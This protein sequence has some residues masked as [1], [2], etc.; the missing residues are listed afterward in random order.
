MGACLPPSAPGKTELKNSAWMPVDKQGNAPRVFGHT[1]KFWTSASLFILG[2]VYVTKK[3]PINCSVFGSEIDDEDPDEQEGR[4]VGNASSL[5]E[6][7]VLLQT[8]TGGSQHWSR[9]AVEAT[10]ET[11]C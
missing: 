11:S 6:Q 2:Y 5:R 10:S 4:H 3:T 1:K 9:P 8:L 7:K